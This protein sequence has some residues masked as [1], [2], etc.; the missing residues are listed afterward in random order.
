MKILVVAGLPSFLP[1]EAFDFII[2]VDRGSLWLTEQ[3]LPLDLAV[4]DF[5]SITEKEKC[6]VK[7]HAKSFVELA[8]EKNDT[9]TEVGLRLAFEQDPKAQVTIIGGMGGRAD[10]LL[11]N[12]FMPISE[13]FKEH[14][15]QVT[16]LDP[17]NE[18]TYFPAGSHQIKNDPSYRYLGF[19]EVGI[20]KSLAIQG[21]KY[22]LEAGQGFSHIYASNEF[23]DDEVS[24]SFA[25]GHLIV[26]RSKDGSPSKNKENI[27]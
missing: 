21:A 10:H 1:D 8:A 19:V 7:V 26:I 6:L 18:L 2:G 24:F 9:D 16:L 11:T 22:E 27:S 20:Q 12:V 13:E 5:D 23:K 15:R 25:E 14:C 17:Q 3:K 4:G